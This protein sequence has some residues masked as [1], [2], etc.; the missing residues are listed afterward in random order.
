MQ[1]RAKHLCALVGLAFGLLVVHYGVI[2]AIFV[3]AMVFVGW[4]VGRILEGE[5]DLNDYIKRRGPDDFE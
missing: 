2:K 4:C 3:V 1:I 5:L